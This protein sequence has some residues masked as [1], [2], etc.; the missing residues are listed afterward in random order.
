MPK[1]SKYKAVT[2]PADS[3]VYIVVQ[4]GVTK[5]VTYAQIKEGL[6][7]EGSV[8]SDDIGHIVK[9]TQAQYDALS[10][11]DLDTLYLIVEA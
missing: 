8:I 1:I 5:R 3:D 11:V 2:A 10:P 7:I 6:V 9:L 4:G